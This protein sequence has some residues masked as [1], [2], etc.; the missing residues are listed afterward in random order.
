MAKLTKKDDLKMMDYSFKDK[1][2]VFGPLRAS[3]EVNTLIHQFN[4]QLFLF[5][6]KPE[7]AWSH[8][9]KSMKWRKNKKLRPE[10]QSRLV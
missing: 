9:V 7:I 2:A 1:K 6:R 5:S 10:T 8:L 4:Y 3:L